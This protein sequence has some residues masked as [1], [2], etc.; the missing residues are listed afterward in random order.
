MVPAG[1]TLDEHIASQTKGK[2]KRGSRI[3]AVDSGR[4]DATMALMEEDIKEKKGALRSMAQQIE[5]Y[6]QR[7]LEM[8]MRE[9][10]WRSAFE[11]VKT[12]AHTTAFSC[13]LLSHDSNIETRISQQL[14]NI[15]VPPSLDIK[16]V[17]CVSQS[18]D[19]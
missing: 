3:E 13:G 14:S 4:Q 9:L 6:K 18:M 5:V 8:K 12:I 16:E 19:L 1:K 10:E 11:Q 17:M 7:L 15:T 2:G